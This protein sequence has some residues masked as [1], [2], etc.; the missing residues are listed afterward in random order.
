MKKEKSKFCKDSIVSL[1]K[2]YR[3]LIHKYFRK[4]K[5]QFGKGL[6][7]CLVKFYQHFSPEYLKEIYI[8]KVGGLDNFYFLSFDLPSRRPSRLGPFS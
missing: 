4:E 8:C 3:H 1:V 5:S 6:V 2:F 7:V